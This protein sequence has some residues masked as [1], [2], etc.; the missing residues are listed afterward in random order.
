MPYFLDES[1]GKI[2]LLCLLSWLQLQLQRH[3]PL[4]SFSIPCLKQV[5]QKD[6]PNR[7]YGQ[8]TSKLQELS[9][10]ICSVCSP[11]YGY[12]CKHHKFFPARGKWSIMHF[13]RFESSFKIYGPLT[14]LIILFWAVN[15]TF[16]ILLMGML[17][18]CFCYFAF[19]IV[20][21]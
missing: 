8:T 1:Y 3:I 18:C 7:S 9:K 14:N 12:S 2:C 11:N 5:V 17:E 21:F 4:R 13:L 20:C 16:L 15:F 19:S 6:C 10:Y